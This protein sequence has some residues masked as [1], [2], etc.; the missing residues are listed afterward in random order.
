MRQRKGLKNL[1][2][3]TP[4]FFSLSSQDIAHTNLVTMHVDTGDSPPPICQ[5]PYTLPLKHYS[6]VQQEIET[7]EHVG[8]IRKNISL[9]ASP[10]VVVPKKSAPGEPPRHRMCMDFRKI[11][12]LQPKIQRVDKQSNTQGNLCL[13]PLP[14][15]DEMYANLHDA[16]IFTTLNLHSGYYHI[17]LDNESKA[18]TAFV[19]PFGKYK[20]N[21]VPFGLAQAPAYFQQ[22]ISIV[23]QDCSNF[24]MA[25][26]DDIIIFSQNEQKH[27]KHIEIIF[28]KLKEAGLKLKESKCDFLK[29][30]IHYLGHLISVD[31]IQPLP[32]KLDSICNIPKPRSPKEIKPFLALTEYYRKFIP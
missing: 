22:I 15:I 11:N 24:A 12:E 29:R 30:E 8:V 13:I 2:K 18:Q 17:A 21:A 28:K 5:K 9:W 20:F 1:K 19:M 32:K 3:N 16:K 31:G 4:K 10:I 26:L 7:L 27:L 23:L 6:W 14:K 25:Y